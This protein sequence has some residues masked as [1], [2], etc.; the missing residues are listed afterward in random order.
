MYD[1]STHK[2][3]ASKDV[4]FHEHVDKQIKQDECNTWQSPYESFKEEEE[5]VELT[6]VQ[7]HMDIP[8][9]TSRNQSPQRSDEGT[10]QRRKGEGT[11]QNNE[12]LRRST[13]QIQAP[14]RYKYYAL[15]S[16]VKPIFEPL[17][18]EQAKNHKEWMKAMK[19]E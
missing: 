8:K 6:Q 15:M 18:Y 1:P 14:I 3:F 7:E 16:Q 13:R 9:D 5:V 17:N 12:P 2:V 10:P 4:I 19:E 11:P